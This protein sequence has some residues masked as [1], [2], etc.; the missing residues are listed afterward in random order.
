MLRCISLR[1]AVSLGLAAALLSAAAW[2]QSEDTQSVAEAARR[3]K[4]KKKVASKPIRVITD[5]DVKPAAPAAPDRA[6][7]PA[8]PSSS[9]AQAAP[10]SGG[11]AP[12]SAPAAKDEKKA[13][14]LADLKAL[15]KEVQN[16]FDV[17]QREQ[18]L[19]QDTYFSNP[20]YVHDAEGKAKLDALKQEITDKQVE[21]ERLKARL[22]ELQPTPDTPTNP[23]PKP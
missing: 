7:A 16:D 23:P 15:I 21:L 2:A 4:E 9:N 14:E 1:L 10:A 22:L 17:L 19:E 8:A 13:K 5:D 12:A 20:D 6:P 18:S 11:S 3:A